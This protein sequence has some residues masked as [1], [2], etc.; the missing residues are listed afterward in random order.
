MGF[1]E[2]DL[3]GPTPLGLVDRTLHRAGDVVGVEDRLA[4]QVARGTTDG[5]DQRALR[6]QEA[7]LVRVED[8]HQR[9]LGHVQAF[10][11]QVDPHQHVE[12]T[13][14]QVADDLH[15]LDGIDVRVQVA[16]PHVVIAEI[17]GEVLGHALGQGSHQHPL[18]L[19]HTLADLREQVI[20]LGHRRAYLDLRIDQPGG[21]H[22]LLDDPPGMFRLIGAGVA[23]T[24]MVCGLT[25]SHSSKRSGRLSSAEGRRKPYS[26]RVSLRERSPLNIAPTCGT[27]T[28]DSSITSS[29][30]AGR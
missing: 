7:F 4:V 14:A 28:C 26:T 2:G 17:I 10:A 13:G 21:T 27:L 18:I 16:H 5:L 19:G 25:A 29:E 12:R 15:S 11:Q 24:K 9:H 20:H 3:L 6:A 8:R 30:L 23:E 1:V 22:H